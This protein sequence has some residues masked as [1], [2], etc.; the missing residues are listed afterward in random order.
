MTYNLKLQG[1]GVYCGLSRAGSREPGWSERRVGPRAGPD[2]SRAGPVRK[3][4]R[5]GSRVGPRDGSGRVGRVGREPGWAGLRAGLG[6][7][8]S[9]RP[10][11]HEGS[12]DPRGAS[13]RAG[14]SRGMSSVSRNYKGVSQRGFEEGLLMRLSSRSRVFQGGSRANSMRIHGSSGASIV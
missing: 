6:C 7:C 5:A 14:G 12:L 8:I 1:L 10:S 9:T 2:E 11:I 3:P 13:C 4:E